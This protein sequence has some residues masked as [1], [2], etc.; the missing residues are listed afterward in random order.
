M[1]QAAFSQCLFL[2]LL[3]HLQEIRAATVIDICGRQVADAV[4]V[5][6]AILLI[7]LIMST[8]T[9]VSDRYSTPVSVSVHP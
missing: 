5:S 3:S 8:S 9:H 6:V 4:V 7:L 2:D 1:L